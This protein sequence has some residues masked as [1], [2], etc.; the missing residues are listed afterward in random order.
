MKSLDTDEAATES[1]DAVIIGTGVGGSTLGLALAAAGYRVL[2]CER[3]RAPAEADSGEPDRYPELASLRAKVPAALDRAALLAAGRY[4][5]RVIDA[6]GNKPYGFIPFIGEGGGGSSALY[7]MVLERFTRADFEPARAHGRDTG[8][9]LPDRWPFGY[10]DLV[11][12]YALA[13]RLYR[14]RGGNDTLR[15]ADERN[16]TGLAAARGTSAGAELERYLE[17]RG[18]HPYRLPLACDD[19]AGCQSCQGY[20]CRRGCKVDAWNACV[21]PAY[22]TGRAFVLDECEVTGLVASGD[23]ITSLRC[24]RAGKAFTLTGRIVALCAGALHS[25]LLLQRSVSDRWSAGVGNAHGLVGRFLMRHLV[26]LYP[27]APAAGLAPDN[28]VKELGFSDFYQRKD[29]KLGGVQSF[30]RLPPVAM[31]IDALAEELR[32]Q[33]KHGLAQLVQWF[34]PFMRPTVRKM[35]EDRLMLA[36]TVEDLP[37]ADNVVT[38]SNESGATASLRYRIHGYE[39]QRV[40]AMRSLVREALGKRYGGIVRQAQNNRRIAHVCGTCRAGASERDSVVGADCRVHGI[41]NLYV[42]D[43]SVFVTSGGT[44]PSLTI[45]A[46]ALRVASLVT[47]HTPDRL[48]RELTREEVS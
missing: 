31:V 37:Y 22:A 16:A 43:A 3:G 19:R 4:S 30:G 42:A 15:P 46:N 10:D 38:P 21:E 7:G 24:V 23:R 18:L 12:F 33:G 1:W 17:S 41:D 34:A 13:E 36:S 8:S 20:A 2:F 40:D 26:D 44:N 6:T 32:E 35:V 27:V 5:H 29:Q 11:P 45:A 9:D 25:P 14:V 47:G 28:R 48:A 39:H